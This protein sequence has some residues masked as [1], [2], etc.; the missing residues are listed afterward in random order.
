[1]RGFTCG[2]CGLLMLVGCSDDAHDGQAA[3]DTGGSQNGSGGRRISGDGSGGTAGAGDPTTT[4]DR[5]YGDVY[6]GQYHLG[7]VDFAESEWHNACAPAGG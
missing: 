2:L 7:P 1:M 4:S 5:L 6:S 3:E